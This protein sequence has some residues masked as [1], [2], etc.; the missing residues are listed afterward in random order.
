MQTVN[1]RKL[2]IENSGY[3]I[4][5]TFP[6]SERAWRN[7]YAPL[8]NRILEVQNRIKDSQAIADIQRELYLYQRY[9]GEFG[10]QFFVA[11]KKP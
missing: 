2:Q 1:V 8:Q 5:N 6:I 9:L 10:Y 4:K 7:Y 11:Q 3:S